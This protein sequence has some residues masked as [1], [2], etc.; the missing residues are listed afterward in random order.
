MAINVFEL[1]SL[2]TACLETKLSTTQ[3]AQALYMMENQSIL[4][5]WVIKSQLKFIFNV[6][7]FNTNTTSDNKNH[8]SPR[9]TPAKAAQSTFT[10]DAHDNNPPSK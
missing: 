8:C 4:D 2:R 3:V 1:P 6:A 10:T 7:C 9:A 5:V